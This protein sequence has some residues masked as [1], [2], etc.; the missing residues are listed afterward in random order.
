MKQIFIN[1]FLYLSLKKVLDFKSSHFSKVVFL[2]PYPLPTTVLLTGTFWEAGLWASEAHNQIKINTHINKE[3]VQ[4]D[5]LMLQSKRTIQ[6][7]VYL[8]QILQY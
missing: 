1:F 5:Y 3:V 7:M 6:S 8:S 2:N 4:L